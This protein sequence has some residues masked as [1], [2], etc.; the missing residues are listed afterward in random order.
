MSQIIVLGWDALDADLIEKYE[1]ED[2]F[3]ELSTIDTYDNPVIDEPHTRELWP[4][5]IT[6]LHPDEHGIHAVSDTDG[7]DWDNP[8]ID[9]LSAVTTGVVPKHVRTAIGK[10]LRQRGAGL[11]AKRPGYYREEGIPTI[12][13]DG[14]R[15]ISIPNYVTAYDEEHALDGNRDDVWAEILPDRD[16]AEGLN[17]NVGVETI[18]STLA[19]AVGD[20]LGHTIAAIEAGHSITWTWFGLVDTVGHIAP[21]VE[22]PLEERAYQLAAKTTETVR[23]MAPQDATV[24]SVS[25]H[26]LQAGEH[27]HYATLATD[28]ER[29]HATISHVFDVAYWVEEARSAGTPTEAGYGVGVEEVTDQLESLGYIEQ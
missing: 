6:G 4:S 15:A 8:L 14:G 28:D 24:V 7:I 3:G 16:G 5:M 22:A 9:W 17:P 18:W 21:A 2:S 23:E 29:A 19:G 20:R 11:D 26:G 12:F 25:D 13:D 27:T 10:R 1:L